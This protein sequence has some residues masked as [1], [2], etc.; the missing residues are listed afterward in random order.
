[1][2]R[3]SRKR[4]GFRLSRC[5]VLVGGKEKRREIGGSAVEVQVAERS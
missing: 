1:L 5:A 2:E 4:E 3:I